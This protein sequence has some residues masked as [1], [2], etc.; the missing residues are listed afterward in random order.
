MVA[1]RNKWT[2]L[3]ASRIH[4]AR[5][6]PF[7]IHGGFVWIA[8]D[9]R[10]SEGIPA[11]HGSKPTLEFHPRGCTETAFRQQILV[12]LFSSKHLE[13]TR[14]SELLLKKN[15]NIIGSFSLLL[16]FPTTVT[17]SK[18]Q[19]KASVIF[20]YGFGEVAEKSRAGSGADEYFIKECI[21]VINTMIQQHV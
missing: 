20:R 21:S 17:L 10:G 6:H 2:R 11:S 8:L 4:G 1:S 19:Q 12:N 15:C 9:L 18:K 7:T 14:Q 3:L 16:L 5:D 13:S